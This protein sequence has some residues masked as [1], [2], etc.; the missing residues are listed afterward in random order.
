MAEIPNLRSIIDKNE[1]E[2]QKMMNN[3]K[4]N[5]HKIDS[6]GLAV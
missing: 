6:L 1:Q 5:I 4:K 2:N 3:F